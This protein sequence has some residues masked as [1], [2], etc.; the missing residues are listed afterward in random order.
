MLT[1][2]EMLDFY[3]ASAS[4]VTAKILRR[5][6]SLVAEHLELANEVPAGLRPYKPEQIEQLAAKR[7]PE[8]VA[9]LI[10]AQARICTAQ[11]IARGG[12]E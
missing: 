4:A 3:A 5:A 8:L 2:D 7:Y 12:H 6:S 1:H 9:A 11:I 10:E